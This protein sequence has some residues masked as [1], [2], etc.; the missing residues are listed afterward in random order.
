[1]TRRLIWLAVPLLAVAGFWATLPP[2]ALSLPDDSQAPPG[3]VRGVVHIHT[4]RSDGG[5]TVDEVAAAAS[6]AGLRFVVVTDHGDG[7][8]VPDPPVYRHGVLVVDGV[9]V[10]TFDGHVLALGIG[11]AP[12]RLGG[13][14]V[15]VVDDIN[16]LGGFAIAA[17]VDSPKR[18]LTWRA[19]DAALTGFE[20]LNADSEWRDETTLSLTTLL[21]QYLVRP[22]E[23]VSRILDRP[24]VSLDRW[25]Q[26]SAS[27]RL[28]TIAAADAHARIG[29]S[30]EDD[31][32]W[33]RRLSLAIPGYE[34]LLRSFSVVATGVR[35]TGDPRVDA[36]AVLA[37]L[38]HGHSYTGIDALAGTGWMRFEAAG[39]G[40][41]VGQGDTIQTVGDVV[42]D[43]RVPDHAGGVVQLLRDG[44]VVREGAEPQLHVTV[45][46]TA[47]TYRV[48]V[49][50]PGAPGMPPV[51]WLLSNPIW[52]GRDEKW[53]GQPALEAA[54][55]GRV[56]V[57]AKG[58]D[59][60]AEHSERSAVA[61]DVVRQNG[62][63]AVLLRYALAGP[64]STGP[65][66]A[67]ALPL[68]GMGGADAISLRCR[69]DRPMRV[70]VELRLMNGE[71][72][73]RWRRSIY[74]DAT[75]T[76]IQVP[77]QSLIRVG[78]DGPVELDSAHV[79]SLLVV[80]DGVNT[81]SGRNGQIWI[82]AASLVRLD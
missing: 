25:D 42:I 34:P 82:E 80:V 36:D 21:P 67:A 64:E 54:R 14:G 39:D 22:V 4:V 43:V 50:R 37:A 17:H 62:V 59:W 45:P 74:L 24:V 26:Q 77:T 78:D 56:V 10:T 58:A 2:R 16:R 27:R 51:P 11:Q 35:L 68:R 1:M 28:V 46:P 31:P 40:R 19:W 8:R 72:E 76:E 69:A 23:A 29:G 65:F 70:S 20:W 41:R 32:R 55:S 13:R 63:E 30:Q 66:A 75:S 15:D 53:G 18:S 9:E 79:R 38:R 49:T 3:D 44:H 57:A 52:V 71:T 60:T 73:E 33:W 81:P 12:Y 5:G 7:T 61:V 47:A 6:R 48:E